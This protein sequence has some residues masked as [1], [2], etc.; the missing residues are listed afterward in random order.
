MG[1]HLEY[2]SSGLTSLTFQGL[3]VTQ[4]LSMGPQGNA[5]RWNSHRGL[6]LGLSLWVTPDTP[7]VAFLGQPCARRNRLCGGPDTRMV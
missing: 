6:R 7:V 4:T 1:K 5:L 3:V 2:Y